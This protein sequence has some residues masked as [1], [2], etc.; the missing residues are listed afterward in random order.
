MPMPGSTPVRTGPFHYAKATMVKPGPGVR[1]LAVTPVARPMTTAPAPPPRP[2][3]LPARAP[4]RRDRP[5][6]RGRFV[7]WMVAHKALTALVAILLVGA[8]IGIALV[9]ISQPFVATPTAGSSPVCFASGDD[10]S[11]LVGLGLSNTPSIVTGCGSASITIYGIPG[12]TSLSL[13]EIL[14]LDNADTADNAAFTVSLSVSGSPAASLTGFTLTFLDDVSGTPT[15]RTWN[16][17]T[18]PTLT[19]YTLSDGETW[20][21]TVSSLL[22][23]AAATGS[24]GALTI[25]A[26]IT[27]V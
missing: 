15:L 3:E 9:I 12:A 21:F 7:G 10:I 23:S 27:Q 20:E 14:E 19:T 5:L 16:L 17:L 6:P 2:P 1:P 18:T 25:T 22:M 13:G 26:T 8:T 24:Q 11:S 4:S